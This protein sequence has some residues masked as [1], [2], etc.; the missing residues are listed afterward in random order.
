MDVQSLF[1]MVLLPLLSIFN[2]E[3]DVHSLL[4]LKQ[5]QLWSRA[6]PR[7]TTHGSALL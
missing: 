1:G 3:T 6:S 5:A 7:G 4:P 2:T